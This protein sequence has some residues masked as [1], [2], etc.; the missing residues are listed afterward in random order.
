MILAPAS[1]TVTVNLT[2]DDVPADPAALE[3]V[4]WHDDAEVATYDIDSDEVAHPAVGQY[5]IEVDSTSP[6]WWGA[7]FSAT[8]DDDADAPSYRSI[9][10][11]WYASR[12]QGPAPTDD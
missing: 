10:T 6:G 12:A 2:R 7:R 11:S 4:V 1:R 8:W 9:E 3:V 5:V